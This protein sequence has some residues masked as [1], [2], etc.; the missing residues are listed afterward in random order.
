MNNLPP[1]PQ[2]GAMGPPSRP[3]APE[4]PEDV[5]EF[6]DIV[7]NAGIDLKAEEALLT[8]NRGREIN[9]NTANPFG[10]QNY[11]SQNIPGG[12]DSFYGAGT[13][14]QPPE[15]A[16]SAEDLATEARARAVRKRAE[17]KS[18]HLNEPFVFAKALEMRMRKKAT[19]MQVKVSFSKLASAVPEYPK[20]ELQI[21]GPDGNRIQKTFADQDWLEH[22]NPWV[23]MLS[24]LS[25]ATEERLR[26]LVE[27]AAILARGRRV[28]SQ[29]KVPADM[30]ELANGA[31]ETAN[32]LP[33]PGNSAVSPKANPLKRMFA[34]SVFPCILLTL[35][36]APTRT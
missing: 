5:K 6:N 25:L 33:S 24:L 15:P 14:N 27:D 1:P 13:F 21:C 11:Y 7:N 19:D 29:G 8:Y 22:E 34:E 23:E 35:L 10:S 20:R 9:N 31:S 32:G 4:K 30:A 28:G 16:K 2:T 26:T 36:Q 18:Y 3:A 17:V 12:R